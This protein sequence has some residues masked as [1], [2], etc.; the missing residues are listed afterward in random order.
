MQNTVEDNVLQT[1]KCNKCKGD[2]SGF[3]KKA[4]C[5]SCYNLKKEK[6]KN[7][8]RA[9]NNNLNIFNTIPMNTSKNEFSSKF[10]K[11]D[12]LFYCILC[13][14]YMNKTEETD[15]KFSHTLSGDNITNFINHLENFPQPE[16]EE[17]YTY[18]VE[19]Q[20]MRAL[21]EIILTS[22]KGMKE[23]ECTYCLGNFEKGQKLIILP[24]AHSFHSKCI[25]QWF[26]KDNTCP[27]CK[28]SINPSILTNSN[29]LLKN[30]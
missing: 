15:H 28:F 20:L 19:E 27:I 1:F 26:T 8:K 2:F 16:P 3:K 14:L 29:L 7:S 18:V 12:D 30:S 5:P 11:E 4:F 23:E 6:N 17:K 24:C 13:D 22:T 21:P 10:A 9:K 25:K